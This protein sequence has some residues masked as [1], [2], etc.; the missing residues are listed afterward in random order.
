MEQLNNLQE[1][2]KSIR[3]SIILALISM[4][5]LVI[6]VVTII[7][8][9]GGIS[10]KRSYL[11]KS[12]DIL[13]P[14]NTSASSIK[15]ELG[16]NAKYVTT[17]FEFKED[18]LQLKAEKLE[19]H[20]PFFGPSIPEIIINSG[21]INVKLK[22]NEDLTDA[23]STI[24]HSL[25]HEKTLKA[26]QIINTDIVVIKDEVAFVLEKIN[27][28]IRTIK[29]KVVV[30]GNFKLGGRVFQVE[31]NLG[32]K[33]DFFLKFESQN[34]SFKASLTNNVGQVM[35]SINSLSSFLNKIMPD[36][37]NIGLEA[38]DGEKNTV[39]FESN[40][41][42][43]D[44]KNDL[45]FS[46]A[47]IQTFGNKEEE[48]SIETLSNNTYKVIIHIKELLLSNSKKKGDLAPVLGEFKNPII[49]FGKIFPKVKA[50]F[51]V[52]IDIIKLNNDQKISNLS[53]T[54]QA[55]YGEINFNTFLRIDDKINAKIEGFIQN[56]E[57]ENR[58][59]FARMDLEGKMN[60]SNLLLFDNIKY[61]GGK[62]E[63]FKLHFDLLLTGENVVLDSVFLDFDN[64]L[65][66]TNSKLEYNAY[67]KEG[68]YLL[69]LNVENLDLNN[70]KFILPSVLKLQNQDLFKTV[71]E[72]LSYKNFVY[73]NLHCSSC[74]I[75]EETMQN[76]E[77]EY[78]MGQGEMEVKK[79]RLINENIDTLISGLIDIRNPNESL[80][81]FDVLINKWKNFNLTILTKFSSIFEDFDSFKAPSLANFSGI[82]KINGSGIEGKNNTINSLGATLALNKGL[83]R[84]TD[85][86]IT[87]NEIKT[88]NFFDIKANLQSNIFDIAFSTSIAG[89]EVKDIFQFLLKNKDFNTISGLIAIGSSTKTNGF[90]IKDLIKNANTSI[91]VKSNALKVRNFNIDAI[92]DIL[93]DGSLSFKTITNSY[94]QDK[95]NSDGLFVAS[96]KVRIN[97]FNIETESIELQSPQSTDVFVIRYNHDGISD[98]NFQVV[99]KMATVGAN[100]NTNLKGAMPVYLTSN[101]SGQSSKNGEAPMIKSDID[102][103][104][105]N[106]Y[107]EAR[108]VL[109][110]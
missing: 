47:K 29:D 66:L 12:I 21:Q 83:L 18:A 54:A 4:L 38:F 36:T 53:F 80:L 26:V 65:K 45:E 61:N 87:L 70:I 91:E 34:L 1:P 50:L 40:I 2:A 106:K 23:I 51:D 96:S 84:T 27:V 69:N 9:A 101:F 92:A 58:K 104:Q 57:S 25:S 78:S 88:D 6:G 3:G 94:I 72:Y 28:D 16:L 108:R 37:I 76:V 13:N 67:K 103:S 97:G 31:L 19:I 90:F 39:Y 109:Y 30:N 107:A 82:F 73:I 7:N 46:N 85:S 14:N 74:K 11:I 64:G 68:Q 17:H 89:L 99:G 48:V 93:L 60:T 62:D 10:V 42:Y 52:K 15:L 24:Y 79:L 44:I 102:Y 32:Q 86:S 56:F 110:K 41:V 95:M 49:Q 35:F 71:F 43:N 100:L 59:G 75:G 22:P 77:F 98:Y 55:L 63:D 20:K 81:N 8:I 33:N 105:I 5:F